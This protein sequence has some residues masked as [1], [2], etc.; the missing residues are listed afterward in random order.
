MK[1]NLHYSLVYPRQLVIQPYTNLSIIYR[2]NRTANRELT[3]ILRDLTPNAVAAAAEA[4]AAEATQGPAAEAPASA[5]H[6]ESDKCI[7]AILDDDPGHLL[8][9]A[10]TVPEDLFQGLGD[11]VEERASPLTCA[12][13]VTKEDLNYPV[14]SEGDEVCYLQDEEAFPLTPE[15]MVLPALQ[16]SKKRNNHLL[17]YLGLSMMTQPGERWM[18]CC[19]VL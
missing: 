14:P 5:D 15:C 9:D 4:H 13:D 10:L 19:G 3:K 12:W 11:I 7:K 2:N 16:V 8:L 6:G 17:K 1:G 18:V